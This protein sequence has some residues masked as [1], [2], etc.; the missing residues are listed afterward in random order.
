MIE[1]ADTQADDRPHLG[2]NLAALYRLN[3][4][5]AVALDARAEAPLLPVEP[6]RN[7]QVTCRMVDAEG[8]PVYLHSRYD[9]VSEAAK[10]IEPRGGSPSR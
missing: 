1:P 10:L 6:T 4:P 7:G 8:R 9:P 3:V 2:K 5:L